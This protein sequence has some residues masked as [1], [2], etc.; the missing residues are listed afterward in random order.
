MRGAD[1]NV[2]RIKKQ[3]NSASQVLVELFSMGNFEDD[4]IMFYTKF[5]DAKK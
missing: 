3:S 5:T 4:V 2:A 1:T